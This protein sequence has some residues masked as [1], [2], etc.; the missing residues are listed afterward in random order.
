M[1]VLV[2]DSDSDEQT[3]RDEDQGLTEVHSIRPKSMEGLAD[4]GICDSVERTRQPE[5]KCENRDD[6]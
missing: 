2:R 4:F 3:D 6:A 1:I 5:T